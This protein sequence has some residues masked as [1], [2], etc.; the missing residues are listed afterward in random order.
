[1]CIQFV[2]ETSLHH[3]ARSEKHQIMGVTYLSQ[4]VA[5]I[6]GTQV[7]SCLIFGAVRYCKHI[8]GF[9][10]HCFVILKIETV[11]NIYP[12][13]RGIHDLHA[14]KNQPV[15]LWYWSMQQS[16][17]SHQPRHLS[18]EKEFTSIDTRFLQV[19]CTVLLRD[20]KI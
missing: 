4:G 20:K 1:M 7:S 15:F 9:K 18:S 3:D 2:I 12:A 14:S 13:F 6:C 16:D 11:T 17:T 5:I 10:G 19:V 8:K